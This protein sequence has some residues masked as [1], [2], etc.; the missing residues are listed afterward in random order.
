MIIGLGKEHGGLYFFSLQSHNITFLAFK[1]D[2][3]HWRLSH[4]SSA[5]LNKI[6]KLS[7]HVSNN[8]DFH[9]DI[10]PLA[11]QTI[12]SFD[13]SSISTTACIQFIHFDI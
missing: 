9:C 4:P 5:R 13:L 6:A 10:C 1:Q 11:K 7:S 8:S 12:V 2:L 3:W